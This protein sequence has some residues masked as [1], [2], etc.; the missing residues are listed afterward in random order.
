MRIQQKK[1]A[2]PESAWCLAI[3]CLAQAGCFAVYPVRDDIV[4]TATSPSGR[5]VAAR[6]VRVHVRAYDF[7][8]DNFGARSCT[9][10]TMTPIFQSFEHRR[11]TEMAR[12]EFARESIT[13]LAVRELRATG[14]FGEVIASHSADADITC[15]VEVRTETTKF[16]DDIRLRAVLTLGLVPGRISGLRQHIRLAFLDRSG[17]SLT[18]VEAIGGFTIWNSVVFV[19]V[20]EPSDTQLDYW[21]IL[22][23]LSKE[24]IRESVKTAVNTGF[25]GEREPADL[26]GAR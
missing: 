14:L 12:P 22:T 21:R 18:S 23:E 24:M 17:Q 16:A 7:C 19:F 4:T 20:G 3:L 10:G 1:C 9:K 5:A 26:P 6:T 13:K 25:L 11:V 15:L 2:T 8:E